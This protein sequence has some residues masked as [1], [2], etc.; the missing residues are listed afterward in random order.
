MFSRRHLIFLLPLVLLVI[1]SCS[2]SEEEEK[3]SIV[4]ETTNK[5]SQDI[6]DSIK[7]PIEQ[8]KLAKEIQ[9]NHNRRVQETIDQ[10]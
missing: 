6:V 2:S 10:Q 4:E 8:A 3:A 7:T 5:I 9:E 1:L